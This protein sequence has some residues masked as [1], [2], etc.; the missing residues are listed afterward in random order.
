MI[1]EAILA[2]SKKQDLNLAE[3]REVMDEIM[4]RH[5]RN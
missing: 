1:Q 4:Q 5:W 2:L 3:A